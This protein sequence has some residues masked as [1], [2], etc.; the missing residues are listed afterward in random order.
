MLGNGVSGVLWSRFNHG[1]LGLSTRKQ[2]VRSWKP[3]TPPPP[4]FLRDDFRVITAAK[5]AF[6]QCIHPRLRRVGFGQ[7]E[8]KFSAIS[9]SAQ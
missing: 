2:A 4:P 5:C 1:D 6:I 7:F 9:L 8:Q 3:P